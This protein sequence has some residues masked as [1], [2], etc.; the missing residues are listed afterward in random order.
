MEALQATQREIRRLRAIVRSLQ[1]ITEENE[2]ERIT[3]LREYYRSNFRNGESD[4]SF[5]LWI[6][7]RI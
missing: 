7:R 4:E 3:Q 6:E 5:L 2:R 1:T